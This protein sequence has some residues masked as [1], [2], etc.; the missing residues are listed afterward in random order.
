MQRTRSFTVVSSRYYNPNSQIVAF[1]PIL[2]LLNHKPGMVNWE[3]DME[4]NALTFA[5]ALPYKQ[6][7]EVQRLFLEF[8][9]ILGL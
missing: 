8:S 4:A 7:D 9:Y 2:D 5:N 1:L 3:Y 6:G